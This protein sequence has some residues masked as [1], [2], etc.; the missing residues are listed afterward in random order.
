MTEAVPRTSIALEAA[1]TRPHR[2][3]A[4]RRRAMWIVAGLAAAGVVVAA[5]AALGREEKA[6]PVGT[7]EAARQ[8]AE[9]G[10]AELA[11]GHTVRAAAMFEEAYRLGDTSE[12]M[13]AQL[14]EAR[15]GAATQARLLVGEHDGGA[16][17]ALIPSPTGERLVAVRDRGVDLWQLGEGGHAW[18]ALAG[19]YVTG[20]TWTP[21]STRVIAWSPDGVVRVWN[22]KT[23]ALSA[24]VQAGLGAVSGVEFEPDGIHAV[25]I[26]GDGMRRRFDLRDPGVIAAWRGAP[27]DASAP[28]AL[29]V[30]VPGQWTAYV[31]GEG[32]VRVVAAR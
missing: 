32:A 22:G 17:R 4:P 9:R 24:T 13:L 25:T 31:D 12:A 6:G 10:K 29:Q 2:M 21:D 20:A 30:A 5:G 16:V 14:V 19:E 3:H 23:G 18:L 15:R 7:R 26:G 11:G 1:Q 8:L 28:G 27:L